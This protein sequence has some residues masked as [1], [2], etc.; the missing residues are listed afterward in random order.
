MK[1]ISRAEFLSIIKT[2][3]KALVISQILPYRE[4]FAAETISEILYPKVAI[5]KGNDVSR[6]TRDALNLIG[7]MRSIIKPNDRV[8]IKPNYITGGLAGHDPVTAGEIPHPDVVIT[9]IEEALK[10]G[11]KEIVVGEWVERPPRILFAGRE[12]KEGAQIAK[13]V[14]QLNK[15]YSSKVYLINLMTYTSYFKYVP[16]K[17][18]LSEI[19]IP[20]IVAESNKII[21]IAVLKT[22]H[23]PSPVTLSMKNYVG[24]MPS[25]LY[26]EPR[27]KLH[28][29]GMNQI[30]VDINKALK[31]CLSVISG[32][33]GMEAEGTTLHLNGKSVD[34]KDR[35]G[36]A[37]VIASKDPLACDSTATRI[38]TSGWDPKTENSEKDIPY[39]IH[40]FRMAYEQG[41][42]EINKELIDVVGENI[43]DVKMHWEMPK[44]VYP[45]LPS[46]E[47]DTSNDP[48]L[49]RL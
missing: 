18:I 39:Y 41:I 35:I 20:N 38:I 23:K 30:I 21:S 1:K 8:F 46:Q 28:S 36:G 45:E 10:C 3:A 37:L 5:T 48:Y 27:S 19:A 12:G 4:I 24:I 49:K 34:I 2:T 42:G 17:T 40:H 31:P 32:V 43:E 25:V 13:R 29:A 9:V 7:T 6:I 44:N 15:K 14:E 16:S 11:A 47:F 33:Y 26:G 22:H